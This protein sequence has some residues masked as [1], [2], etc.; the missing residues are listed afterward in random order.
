[1]SGR[2]VCYTLVV[3][4]LST[5]LSCKQGNKPAQEPAKEPY[6]ESLLKERAEKDAQLLSA[7]VIEDEDLKNFKGLR[8]YS[9]DPAYAIK[10]AVHRLPPLKITFKTTNDRAPEYYTYAR[11]DFKAGDSA[12]SL[13]AYSYDS[14]GKEGLFIPFGD[15]S[16]KKETYGGGRYL[17][18]PLK[19]QSDSI[20]LDFNRAYN[21]YCHY[22]HNYS[23]PLVPF[24]NRLNVAI[25]AGEKT[26]KAQGL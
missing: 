11:L 20:L 12:C 6:T 18:V 5:L 9:P 26:L 7:G 14:E 23:C 8:Y 10:A 4:I 22:N 19:G 1:M 13:I 25:P 3:L 16:N 2:I 15:L 21:P 24:E 17:D